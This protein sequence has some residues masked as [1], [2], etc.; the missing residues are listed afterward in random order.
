MGN[1]VQGQALVKFKIM[2]ASVLSSS[3]NFAFN[4]LGGTNASNAFD[5]GLP[6]FFGRKVYIGIETTSSSLGTGPYYGF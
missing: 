4:N 2:D 3:A 6:F 1:Q 5:W